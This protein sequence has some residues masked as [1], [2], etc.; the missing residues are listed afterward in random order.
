LVD[1]EE[2]E[3][4][5]DS[6]AAAEGAGAGAAEGDGA[7]AGVDAGAGDGGSIED[8]EDVAISSCFRFN[9]PDAFSLSCVVRFVCCVCCAGGCTGRIAE[10][11]VAAP[12]NRIGTRAG[13]TSAAEMDEDGPG[14]TADT[15]FSDIV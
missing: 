3:T 6:T 13:L 9:W 1:A 11:E 5:A 12:G 10:L 14:T 4:E 15:A 2:T 8:I 7:A